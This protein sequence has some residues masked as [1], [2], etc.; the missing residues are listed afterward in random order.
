LLQKE[1]EKRDRLKELGIA[2]DFTGYVST[3]FAQSL[4]WDSG[5]LQESAALI[6]KGGG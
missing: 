6:G 1:K 4:G 3:V 5:C 2:Y